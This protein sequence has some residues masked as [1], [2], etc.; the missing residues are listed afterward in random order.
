[1]SDQARIFA[2]LAPQAAARTVETVQ[3][4]RDANGF[5]PMLRTAVSGWLEVFR[6]A[7]P[8]LRHLSKD[9]GGFFL[10]ML[11]MAMQ[12][13]HARIPLRT[14]KQYCQAGG[15]ASPGRVSAFVGYLV[16][17]G[18]IV[19]EAG[20]EGVVLT[21]TEGLAAL[22][23]DH[24]RSDIRGLG[25]VTDN[26]E[27]A[28]E[29]LDGPAVFDAARWIAIFSILSANATSWHSQVIGEIGERTAGMQILWDLIL[30]EGDPDPTAASE[31]NVSI[32]ALARR[33]EVSRPHVRKLLN[34]CAADGFLT[35]ITPRR[36][37]FTPRFIDAATMT[38]SWVFTG[39]RITFEAWLDDRSGQ[40]AS[41]AG[42]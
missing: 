17:R 32:A 22:F 7:P 9:R 29:A 42:V 3:A 5:N 19:Q 24:L 36:V 39:L 14:V 12:A 2:A 26:V 28:L 30:S 34:D 4:S 31:A 20:E 25:L 40:N 15:I 33:Y 6:A 10:G 23:R 41:V 8:E 35:W 37:A 13:D 27:G 16:Q 18:F 11:L 38:W 1:V 21:L